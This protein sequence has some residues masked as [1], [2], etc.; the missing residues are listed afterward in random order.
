MQGDTVL[1]IA[2]SSTD[3]SRDGFGGGGSA[4]A[5]VELIRC[6]AGEAAACKHPVLW[7][8]GRGMSVDSDANGSTA[9]T[10][11]DHQYA[12]ELVPGV[13]EKRTASSTPSP[14]SSGRPNDGVAD[15]ASGSQ[16]K[17]AWQYRRYLAANRALDD[18]DGGAVG[19]GAL[20]R[21]AAGDRRR[22]NISTM[23]WQPVQSRKGT[24]IEPGSRFKTS[25][26]PISKS[27]TPPDSTE[28][29]E[30]KQKRRRAPG[31]TAHALDMTRGIG[32]ESARE[33]PAVWRSV[34]GSGAPQR[35]ADHSWAF[36]K[37]CGEN[38]RH[39]CVPRI[40]LEC[41]SGLGD[42][43]LVPP[44]AGDSW[45]DIENGWIMV[46]LDSVPLCSAVVAD[47]ESLSVLF[48][49]LSFSLQI[50]STI[51]SFILTTE[52]AIARPTLSPPKT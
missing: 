47:S 4:L 20:R 31:A 43:G 9:V 49:S 34:A 22:S 26:A 3:A 50:Q 52:R 14:S 38:A 15:D 16:L 6:A 42:A 24:S 18:R 8:N 25:V 12:G 44:A 45:D 23:Q 1:V 27:G 17:I 13:I 28:G 36:L 46:R 30:A 19:G 5:G 29:I 33:L 37:Q 10:E 11:D 48:L 41:P 7:I 40:I 39:G 2:G 35:F 21:P 51:A 32:A